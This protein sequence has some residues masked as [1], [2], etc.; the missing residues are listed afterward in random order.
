MKA[1]TLL[2]VLLFS[3][4]LC[5]AAEEQSHGVIFEKWVR[6]TFFNGYTPRSYTQK[7]DIPADQNTAH[8]GIPANPKATKY[9]TPVDMGD[10]LRQFAVTEGKEKFLIIV[11]FWDQAED[12]KH[13]VLGVP[14]EITP[15][16]YRKLW[17]PITRADLEAL[18]AVVK[19]KTLSIEAAR[20]KAQEIKTQ[21]PYT[22]AIMQ[23]NPKLD[24]K[25]RRLQCSIRFADFFKHLA[26]ETKPEHQ[27]Q[28][29]LWGEAMPPPFKSPARRK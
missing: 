16:Q 9:N 23:V 4:W 7:W 2:A 6:D 24:G 26:P 3:A 22:K 27:A 25:Q 18:D 8:G 21:A 20:A 29:M 15:E 28:P 1:W 12:E 5:P 10:A 13:W 14:A 17:E 19:D 11:G